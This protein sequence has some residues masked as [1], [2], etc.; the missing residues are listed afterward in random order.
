MDTP[1]HLATI[2]PLVFLRKGPFFTQNEGVELSHVT[3]NV[4][5]AN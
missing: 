2:L 4:R 5:A 3:T 1:T